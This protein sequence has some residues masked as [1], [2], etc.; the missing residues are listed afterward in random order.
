VRVIDPKLL[1]TDPD[2]LRRAQEARGESPE[3]VDRLL[4]ADE[5]RRSSIAAFER[6]RAEQKELGGRIP[7]ASADERQQLLAR[8]KE[9]AAQVKDAQAA[10]DEAGS[11]FDALML[12][13][14]N[15]VFDDVPRGG[16]DD[17]VVVEQVGTPRDFEAEGFTARDHLEI[18]Q[19]LGA[20]DMERGAKVSGS[21][22][23]FLTGQGAQLELALTQLA[24]AKA[25]EWGFTPIL[26]PALVKPSAMEGTGFLGQAAQDV[27]HLPAD[28][29]YLVGTSEVALAAYHSEEILD[30]AQLPISYAGY[31]PC[32]RREAGSYG[33]DTKGI[34]RVHWFDKVEMFVYCAPEDAHAQH[35]RLLE[36]EKEFLS[37]LGLPFQV[38]EVAAGDLG[39]SAARKYDCYGWVPS[40]GKYREITST[41]NCTEFQSRRLNTRARYESG[42]G[43][44][45]TLN[46]TLC[47]MTRMII[48]L[49]ENHQ[50]ADGSVLVP[51]ALRPYLGGRDRL[52]PA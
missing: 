43:P 9:L 10:S 4:A 21:R 8:T 46:G 5:T 44:V 29:L 22:F 52:T 51:E 6:L 45:A 39:L 28:D 7:K 18:G 30:A 20:I 49:L 33:K 24:M 48:L 11:T 17:F 14:P 1:R 2:R 23:Y 35:Q 15:P 42:V 32:F 47:A 36:Y 37:L 31:S 38:L 40:Q 25:F 50:Q 19:V 13:L 16:E 26:P 3:L 27:Y 41:S 12:Q 34:F